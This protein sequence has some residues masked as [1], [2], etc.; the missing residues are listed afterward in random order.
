MYTIISFGLSEMMGPY[1][2]HIDKMATV[3]C[4]RILGLSDWSS[5]GHCMSVEFVRREVLAKSVPG[6]DLF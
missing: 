3:P 2:H 5:R 1:R 6:E 4:Q